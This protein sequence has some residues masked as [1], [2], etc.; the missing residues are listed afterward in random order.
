M[1]YEDKGVKAKRTYQRNGSASIQLNPALAYF[2]ELVKITIYRFSLWPIYKITCD[3]NLN[4][5]W[6]NTIK[7]GCAIVGFYCVTQNTI[8]L[9]VAKWLKFRHSLVSLDISR[10]VFFLL[11][12]EKISNKIRSRTTMLTHMIFH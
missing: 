8:I 11:S 1:I 12:D 6:Q 2:K 10:V 9:L 4:A 5:H 3:E 7:S